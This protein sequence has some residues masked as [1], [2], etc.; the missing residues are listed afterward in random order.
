[1]RSNHISEKS[2]KK[3]SGSRMKSKR[4]SKAERLLIRLW[5]EKEEE[6]EL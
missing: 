4:K 3:K 1:M 2:E 5:I 6:A